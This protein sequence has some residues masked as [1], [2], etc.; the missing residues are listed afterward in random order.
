MRL[1]CYQEE[2]LHL[3]AVRRGRGCQLGVFALPEELSCAQ[4]QFHARQMDAKAGPRSCAKRMVHGLCYFLLRRE[5]CRVQ[6]KLPKRV[7]VEGVFEDCLVTVNGVRLCGD[8]STSWYIIPA[9]LSSS[10]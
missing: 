6:L 7:E 10:W 1:R 5:I 8:G 4:P 9:R 3:H 2:V